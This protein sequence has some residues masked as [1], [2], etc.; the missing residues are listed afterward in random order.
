MIGVKGGGGWRDQ[1]LEYNCHK[2]QG[3]K[4][5]AV[6]MVINSEL[7]RPLP[8]YGLQKHTS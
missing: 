3:D 5:E 7:G 2:G 6:F 1:D 4:E 8:F